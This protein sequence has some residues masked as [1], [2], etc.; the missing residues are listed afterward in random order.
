MIS[1]QNM[2][3]DP[4]EAL[5][6]F[7][8]GQSV[9]MD[10][11]RNQTQAAKENAQDGSNPNAPKRIGTSQGVM[12][13]AGVTGNQNPFTMPVGGQSNALYGGMNQMLV[14]PQIPQAQ[15]SPLMGYLNQFYSSAR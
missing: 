4:R 2:N 7:Y 13:M 10:T 15:G 12:G 5:Q 8:A 1:T 14:N 9:A 6:R 11:F 3:Y